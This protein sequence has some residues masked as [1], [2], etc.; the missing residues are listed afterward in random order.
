MGDASVAYQWRPL[1]A[2]DVDA[3]SALTAVVAAADHTSRHYT[4][5]DLLEELEDPSVDAARDT[6]GVFA[7]SELVAVG[8]VYR[9]LRRL[10]G[11]L[12][13]A[14]D[15]SVHPD[16]RGRG[17]GGELLS[18]LEQRVI[19]SAREHFPDAAEIRPS[20]DAMS[21]SSGV[22]LLESRG[23]TPLRYFHEMTHDRPGVDLAGGDDGG[24]RLVDY[25]PAR[26]GEVVAAYRA[27]FSTHWGFV[28]PDAARWRV[29]F[30]GSRTFR[31]GC[32]AL[33]LDGGGAVV[34]LVLSYEYQPGEL[35]FGQV[36]VVPAARGRGVATA[37]LR[38][39]LARAA[40]AGYA[41]VSLDVD[42]AN[43]DGAG[44]LYESVGFRRVRT[45]IVFVRS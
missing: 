26:D 36:G 21:G 43:A 25:D 15:G 24:G 10:D 12:R 42:S 6:V 31:P 19:E 39:C 14:F 2:A 3:W 7:G 29:Q 30:T 13:T 45:S 44:H 8:Q 18:R 16:H 20:T 22:A 11:T 27:A 9:P 5:A 35:W 28:P 23:Y 37:L 1:T 38:R 34:G 33:A 17:I 40:A 32:S 4:A 41:T